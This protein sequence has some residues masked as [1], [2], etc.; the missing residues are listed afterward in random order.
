[1]REGIKGLASFF[2]F[3]LLNISLTAC[4]PGLLGG[5]GGSGGSGAATASLAKTS[6]SIDSS[7]MASNG[8][9]AATIT[10]ILLDASGNPISGV[11]P[12]VT[13]SGNS[14][15]VTVSGPSDA[16]GRVTFQVTSSTNGTTTVAVASPSTLSTLS[17]QVRFVTGHALTSIAATSAPVLLARQDHGIVWTG[18]KM[19]VW[20]GG[21]SSTTGTMYNDGGIYDPVTDTWNTA[22][23]ASGLAT[24]E[25]FA[26][27]WA[28]SVSKMLVWGGYNGANVALGDGAMF[29][30][31]GAGSWTA[32][33]NTSAPWKRYELVAAWDDLNNRMIVYNGTSDTA[34]ARCPGGTP[35][36]C[37]NGGFFDPANGANGTW[38]DFPS[39][40]TT[41]GGPVG[42]R[43]ATALW[44]SNLGRFIVWGGNLG[45]TTRNDGG[46]LD[47]S[48]G[49]TAISAGSAPTDRDELAMG[50][51]PSAKTVIVWGGWSNS[52]GFKQD[53]GLL[54]LSGGGGGSW[55]AIPNSG[56]AARAVP[57]YGSTG[58]GLIVWGGIN[59]GGG[60]NDGAVYTYGTGWGTTIATAA[61]A[62][63]Y[64]QGT[65]S[66]AGAWTGGGLLIWG[67]TTASTFGTLRN[68]GALITP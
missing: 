57:F 44:A 60:F 34:N 27:V 7:T 55:T 56:P 1:M 25:E 39:G 4:A 48:S 5:V 8:T 52:T 53:G 68:S 42:R 10:L 35:K 15:T 54:D 61:Q 12:T 47:P 29:D 41:A 31:S 51:V 22:L 45:G 3:I 58:T 13:V 20:G 18:S 62:R 66:G 43:W 14:A 16:S 36:Y 2:A 11:T 46:I 33:T 6:F 37:E 26:A 30:P 40:G 19:I 63:G 9:S 50:Y 17:T 32:M 59:G 24:R 65:H 28:K 21:D 49:W 23:P 67:G 38:T 64:G